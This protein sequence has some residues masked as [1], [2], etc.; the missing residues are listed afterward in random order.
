MRTI[1]V[2]YINQPILYC[3][4]EKELPSV[5][6]EYTLTRITNEAIIVSKWIYSTETGSFVEQIIDDE[7][8]KY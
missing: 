4:L 8:V 6:T 1:I 7:L 5:D 3:F 2:A